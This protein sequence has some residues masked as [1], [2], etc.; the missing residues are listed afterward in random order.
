MES[1]LWR[2]GKDNLLL[3]QVEVHTLTKSELPE[4]GRESNPAVFLNDAE[5]ALLFGVLVNSLH[6]SG[7]AFDVGGF[8]PANATVSKGPPPH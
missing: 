1:S 6:D 7:I 2:C 5:I 8:S 4:I 3:E